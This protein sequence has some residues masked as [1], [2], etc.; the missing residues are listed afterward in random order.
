MAAYANVKT[1]A[2]DHIL[3]YV[4]RVESLIHDNMTMTLSDTNSTRAFNC[5]VDSCSLNQGD[6]NE[7]IVVWDYQCIHMSNI[8]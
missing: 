8:A 5:R 7:Y 6:E 3:R 1:K 4:S 2:L